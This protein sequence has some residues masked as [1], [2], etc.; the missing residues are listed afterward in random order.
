MT[1]KDKGGQWL[2]GVG[3]L[4]EVG[5]AQGYRAVSACFFPAGAQQRSS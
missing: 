1:S 2:S 4:G 5:S 3:R